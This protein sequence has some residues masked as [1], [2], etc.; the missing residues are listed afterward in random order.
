[1]SNKLPAA[2]R[3]Y[4]LLSATATPF[5]PL[6]LAQRLK[7]GK[8]HL[9]R[10][11]E[12]RGFARM[13]R[14]SGPL[15]WVHGASV[16]E[17]TAVLPLIERIA[18]RDLSVLVTTGTVTSG[19]LAAQ[20]LPHGVIHQFVPLDLPR[21]VNRFLTHWRPD[22]ALFVEQDLW[23]NMIVEASR[24]CVPMIVVNGRLSEHSFRR[25][26]LLP[27]MIVDLL[28]RFDLCLAGSADDAARFGALGARHV[29]TTGNLKFDVPA[30]LAPPDRL[31]AL[32]R[33]I[34]RRPVIAAA[35]THAGEESA[36]IAAHRHLRA[37]FPGLI[38]LIAPR[39]TERGQG[40]VDL[41]VTAGLKAILRSSGGRPNASTDI[42]VLDT[43]GELG[44]IYRLAPSV[45]IGGSLVP[46]GGQNPIEAAKL[47]AAILHG[48]HVANFAE[49]YG[50]LDTAGGAVPV[51]D[52]ERLIAAYG[53]W[54]NDPAARQRAADAA[55]AT[56][57]TLSGALAR[58]LAALEPYL[59]Q[60]QLHRHSSHA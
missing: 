29:I 55:R 56:V 33:A 14:A 8:E 13:A 25:W 31:E 57:E 3:A 20:R 9:R 40:V 32:W 42:Y 5:A 49:I 7:R 52:G 45:F 22:L 43:M 44:L 38:T 54:L 1:M 39:H 28:D 10:L 19:G 46:H 30:P 4:R 27:A 21:F 47:G 6:L 17:L 53:A 16:G 36:V 2:L 18:A 59:M 26:R 60:L 35:S 24:R 50:A 12:R 58:T 23:P 48:P 37:N 15:V 11:P 51:A 41:A 34:G